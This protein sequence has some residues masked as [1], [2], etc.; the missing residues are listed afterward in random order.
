MSGQQHHRRVRA[1]RRRQ[2]RN[3]IGM[4]LSARHQRDADIARQPRIGV[5]HMHGRR[6]MPNM[7]EFDAR[8]NAASNTG[9][10]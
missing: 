4:S 1:L 7:D 10:M 2:R 3:R 5:R 8:P 9:M 6:L